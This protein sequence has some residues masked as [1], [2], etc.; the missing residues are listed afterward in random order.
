MV[1]IINTV[2]DFAVKKIANLA[3]TSTD[4]L[5]LELAIL[6]LVVYFFLIWFVFEQD[7]K[8]AAAFAF[9]PILLIDY[10]FSFGK[11]IFAFPLAIPGIGDTY[12][13]NNFVLTFRLF[14]Y[15]FNFGIW[16]DFGLTTFNAVTGS[17]L[18]SSLDKILV[19]LFVFADSILI[20][21]LASYIIYSFIDDIQY[22]AL[23]GA[24]AA[25]A[26]S[27]VSNPFKE[28]KA[29]EV[30][31]SH[32]R[33]FIGAATHEQL[34]VVLG[35]AII[36]FTI[37]VFLL[38]VA[39]NLFIAVGKTTVNP[40]LESKSWEFNITGIAFGL[41]IFYAITNLLHPKYAWYVL[42]PVLVGYS[43]LKSGMSSYAEGRHADRRQREMI[44]EAVID[45]RR[46]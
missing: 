18:L 24:F 17:F 16:K 30:T 13:L 3:T 44:A 10:A 4:I 15:I 38:S 46:R 11:Y 5:Y 32:V 14:D 42:L 6:F 36:S 26:Y 34:I 25:L 8:L 27:F 33:Y 7:K 1:E 41:A 12:T 29:A 35:A 28:F 20:F 22:S 2:V 31:V 9:V 23:G 43:I 19:F 39:T 45:A 40:R 21:I 37:I